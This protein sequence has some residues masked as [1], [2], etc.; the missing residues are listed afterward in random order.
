MSSRAK[1]GTTGWGRMSS[2]DEREECTVV[3]IK[4]GVG[5]C[6]GHDH[7]Q[8]EAKLLTFTPL[9]TLTMLLERP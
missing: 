2:G 5:R 1:K 9:I 7:G 8:G 4:F 6:Y 3:H